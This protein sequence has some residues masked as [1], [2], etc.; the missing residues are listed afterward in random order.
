MLSRYSD[1]EDEASSF[2][3]PPVVSRLVDLCFLKFK[4]IA[5]ACSSF[6]SL[7][8]IPRR[9]SLLLSVSI[10]VIWWRRSFGFDLE[11][12]LAL[13]F[14]EF[15]PLFDVDGELI[16]VSVLAGDIGCKINPPW[17][18]AAS[19]LSNWLR[20]RGEGFFEEGNSFFSAIF[21]S[22]SYASSCSLLS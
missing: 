13:L 12:M 18:Y 8:N 2:L 16:I 11:V 7:K 9:F 15:S 5:F 10:N 21:L 17:S 22:W 6:S 19:S 1:E 20:G 4:A 14:R 3:A